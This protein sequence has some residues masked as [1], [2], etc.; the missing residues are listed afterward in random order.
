MVLADAEEVDAELVGQ[1]RLLDDVADHLR[2]RQQ[3]PVGVHGDVAERVQ[4]ELQFPCHALS[5]TV[6]RATVPAARACLSVMTTRAAV[7]RLAPHLER[8]YG[9]GVSKLTPLEPWAP[10]HAQRVDLDDGRSWVA[11]LHPPS[12][13]GTEVEGDAELL[14]FLEQHDYPA[15]R[16]VADGDP[17]STL[18][19][20]DEHTI[21]LT[22]LIPGVNCRTDTS[23]A[24]VGGIGELLGRLHA[25]SLPPDGPVTREAGGWH[26]LSTA[27][28]GRRADVEA[29]LPQLDAKAER[30]P[31]DQQ[32]DAHRLRDALVGIDD[33]VDLAPHVL[34]NVDF[35]GPNIMR[36]PDGQLVGIDWTGAGRGPRVL[37]MAALGTKGGAPDVLGPFLEGYLRHAPPLG[38]EELDRLPGALA[39]HGFILGCWMYVHRDVTAATVLHNYDGDVKEGER[40]TEAV[41]RLL[42]TA[43][44]A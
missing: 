18:D 11:R 39:L 37:S 41:R 3:R 10:E 38:A 17:V 29:L 19:D 16:L 28:G 21:L 42:A 40:V 20:P 4:P 26:H 23:P 9:V 6:A 32:D 33:C 14:R 24:T 43:A 34:I 7:E 12:R 36:T 8:T 30:I 22:V 35:G 31:D 5:N 27:G 25:L 1:H 2:L 15:E 13:P 44:G